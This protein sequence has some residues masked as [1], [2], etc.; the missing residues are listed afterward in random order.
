[1]QVNN[2][3][4]KHLTTLTRQVALLNSRV[5]PNNE[6]CGLCGALGHGANMCPQNIYEPEQVN[7]MNANQP[8]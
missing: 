3:M 2:E 4:A 5:Q 6:V 7:F 8:R 1:M